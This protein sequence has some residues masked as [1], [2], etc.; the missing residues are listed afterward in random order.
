MWIF[1]IVEIANKF[2][3]CII[4]FRRWRTLWHVTSVWTESVT[5]RSSVDT[6]PVSSVL[7]HSDNVTCVA[8]LSLR[9]SICSTD[10]LSQLSQMSSYRHEIKQCYLSLLLCAKLK[11]NFMNSLLYDM[12]FYFKRRYIFL[13]DDGLTPKIGPKVK[14]TIHL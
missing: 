7:N 2:C 11:L 6:P 8:N 13:V 12:R 9:E 3:I 10:T 1:Q 4:L 14:Y 5:S